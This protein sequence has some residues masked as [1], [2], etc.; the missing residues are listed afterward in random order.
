MSASPPSA[1]ARLLAWL[2][3]VAWMALIFFLSS[4]PGLRIAPDSLLD[5]VL[6]KA[7][8]MFMFGVLAVLIARAWTG[9][10][11][12]LV[13]FLLAVGYAGTD[14]WHQSFVMLR[15]A[16]LADVGFDAA[17]AVIGLA[18]WS[19]VRGR[20]APLW[21]ALRRRGRTI[22]HARGPGRVEERGHR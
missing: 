6:R 10:R 18:L 20:L 11:T 16:D 7:G 9:P 13:A 4:L 17:G 22:T 12:A 21:L 19:R 3:V 8:H 5:F 2:P 1:K 14:E 15:Q